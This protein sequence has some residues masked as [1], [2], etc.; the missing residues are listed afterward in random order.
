[1]GNGLW[2]GEGPRWN[3]LLNQII[4]TCMHECVNYHLVILS[5]WGELCDHE[6][7][8][9]HT[10]SFGFF[11][12]CCGRWRKWYNHLSRVLNRIIG[13]KVFSNWEVSRL[14]T[15]IQFLFLLCCCAIHSWNCFTLQTF[16]FAERNFRNI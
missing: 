4:E 10:E 3:V 11:V 13:F 9:I 8:E 1:M 14:C 7:H 5:S 2:R 16:R 6:N 12:S 15:L